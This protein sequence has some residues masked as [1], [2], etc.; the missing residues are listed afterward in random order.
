M[1]SICALIAI[2]R[3]HSDTTRSILNYFSRISLSKIRIIK[4]GISSESLRVLI[5]ALASC[6][7]VTQLSLD[8]VSVASPSPSDGA[9]A[10]DEPASI[11]PWADLFSAASPL[12]SVSL[13]G[14]EITD[15][16]RYFDCTLSICIQMSRNI[17][18]R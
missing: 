11:E 6:S 17:Y 3:E 10:G 15:A 5:A 12:Q 18:L 2:S 8:Y 14:N 9:A 1:R 7:T 4:I 13:R 16:V